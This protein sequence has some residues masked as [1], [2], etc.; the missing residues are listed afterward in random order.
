M[1]KG[2]L[3][4]ECLPEHTNKLA[5]RAFDFSPEMVRQSKIKAQQFEIPDENCFIG[6]AQHLPFTQEKFDKIYFPLSV[7]SIPNPSLALREAERVLA[8]GG[9]IVIFDKLRDDDVPL[10]WTR[11]ALNVVTKCVFADITRNL[12]SILTSV[13]T[14]KIVHYESLAGKLDGVFARYTGQYYRIAVVMRHSDYPD[15]AVVPAKLQ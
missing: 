15:Q 13:P 10:S 14:L 12:S 8:P 4:L 2:G 3:D 11:T 5:L 1:K 9:K 7:E 6:D